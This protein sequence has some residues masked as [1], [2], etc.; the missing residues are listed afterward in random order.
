MSADEQTAS[1]AVDP[2]AVAVTEATAVHGVR[3]LTEE[4]FRVVYARTMRDVRARMVA[5][6]QAAGAP[7]SPR[8]AAAQQAAANFAPA[9]PPPAAAQPVVEG[10]GDRA[11]AAVRAMVPTL[12]WG[13]LKLSF[14][15]LLFSS[16]GRGSFLSVFVTVLVLKLASVGMSRIRIRVHHHADHRDAHPDNEFFSD[17]E[18]VQRLQTELDTNPEAVLQLSQKRATFNERQRRRRRNLVWWKGVKIMTTF[19]VSM[20]PSWRTENLQAE[21]IADGLIKDESKRRPPRKYARPAE[22][23]AAPAMDNAQ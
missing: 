19:V 18:V 3:P 8:P 21:L 7:Q 5:N 15:A 22:A 10:F 20:F 1:A 4:E 12:L 9:A 13:A 23:G 6:Q 16:A 14:I 11:A 17:D 2:A